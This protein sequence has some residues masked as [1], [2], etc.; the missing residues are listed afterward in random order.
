M[1]KVVND[2]VSVGTFGLVKDVTGTEGA[3]KAADRA[4][5]VQAKGALT[6]E[7][8]INRRFD[9]TQ[10][11]LQPS[12]EAGD[13]ARKQQLA[14]LGL[15]EEG[16]QEEA[17]QAFNESPGQKFLRDR[18]E[19]ATVRNAGAIG[20]LGGGNVRKALTEFGIGTA[21]QDFQNQFGRLGQ[22]AGQGQSA[23]TNVGQ[24]G[25][26]AANQ[27]GQFGVAGSEARASGILGKAQAESQFVN[28]GLQ[29]GG[30]FLGAAFG[31]PAKAAGVK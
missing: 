14:L 6:A 20:G 19:R 1:S 12:V 22:L 15:G 27:A 10:A 7:Q 23:A 5:G 8:G 13:L 2:V 9:L 3:K 16:E 24:F 29:L 18:G 28:Q 25:A 26:S 17:F 30:Q 4:A 21:Q 31:S 11:S